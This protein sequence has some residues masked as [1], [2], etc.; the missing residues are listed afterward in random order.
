MTISLSLV[1]K[2][3]SAIW[4]RMFNRVMFP[5]LAKDISPFFRAKLVK[6]IQNIEDRQDAFSNRARDER[7]AQLNLLHGKTEGKGGAA[8]AGVCTC[9][10]S[11]RGFIVSLKCS[12]IPLCV[13]RGRLW[14]STEPFTLYDFALCSYLL[15]FSPKALAL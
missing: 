11:E 5:W 7:V 12:Q 6:H 14:P 15:L 13:C 10:C 1:R 3:G 4:A 8:A 2:P 9:T